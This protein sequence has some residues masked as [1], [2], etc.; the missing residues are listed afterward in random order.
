MWKLS[1]QMQF[2]LKRSW[3]IHGCYSVAESGGVPCIVHNRTYEHGE[4]F[5]LDCRTQC[6]CQVGPIIPV[7]I[8]NS[9]GIR[10]CRQGG[11]SSPK[12]AKNE[13]FTPGETRVGAN[14]TVSHQRE[15]YFCLRVG[16]GEAWS[17]RC[18]EAGRQPPK[19]DIRNYDTFMFSWRF[20]T[21]IVRKN[22][23]PLSVCLSVL[24]DR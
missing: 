8:F 2:P 12:I 10:Q 16:G 7:L 13:F 15:E 14:G 18:V 22:K 5:T 23:S 9:G 19:R 11:S 17:V 1:D 21:P 6:A 4:T 3:T 24:L 20:V